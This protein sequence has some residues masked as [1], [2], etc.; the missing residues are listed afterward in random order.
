MAL[1]HSFSSSPGS[2]MTIEKYL[3]PINKS[4]DQLDK[5]RHLSVLL[6]PRNESTNLSQM[7]IRT[8]EFYRNSSFTIMD[9][10]DLLQ[11]SLLEIS[12]GRL[13]MSNFENQA[14]VAIFNNVIEELDIVKYYLPYPKFDWNKAYEDPDSHIAKI[15]G[16]LL[17]YTFAPY[18]E[19][20]NAPLW[21]IQLDR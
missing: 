6:K 14:V 18:N 13:Q 15:S 12:P 21:K 17:Q 9:H 10:D 19:Y 7:T 8:F 2:Y 16:K 11:K 5:E 1:P 20:E 3:Y 4:D